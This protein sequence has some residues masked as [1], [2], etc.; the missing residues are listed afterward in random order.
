M[1]N[2]SDGE[3]LDW[4]QRHLVSVHT[5]FTQTRIMSTASFGEETHGMIFDG[6]AVGGRPD[7]HP[8]IREAIDA[9]MSERGT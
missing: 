3:R 5:V 9:A 4:I 6:W 7:A 8:T 2:I 1:P